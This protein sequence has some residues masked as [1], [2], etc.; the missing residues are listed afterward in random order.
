MFDVES[1]HVHGVIAGS[2]HFE[3]MLVFVAVEA[4]EQAAVG[5]MVR[6]NTAPQIAIVVV[7]ERRVG[8]SSEKI[9]IAVNAFKDGNVCDKC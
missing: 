7:S 8:R 6:R 2:D 5:D 1:M 3:P 9:G 4:D